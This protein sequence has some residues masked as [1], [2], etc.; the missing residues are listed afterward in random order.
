MDKMIQSLPIVISSLSLIVAAANYYRQHLRQDYKLVYNFVSLIGAAHQPHFRHHFTLANAGNKEVFVASVY[1][2]VKGPNLYEKIAADDSENFKGIFKPGEIKD[3]DVKNK[4]SI[5]SKY[6]LHPEL[7]PER[8]EVENVSFSSE[9]EER[10]T[11]KII[12]EVVVIQS[13]GVRKTITLPVYELLI[14][15][16]EAKAEGRAY[17]MTLNGKNVLSTKF[18]SA[19]RIF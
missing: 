19:N 3:F 8:G 1:F 17:D 4:V 15:F 6:Q 5:T 7:R 10:D 13:N 12:I 14:P 11:Y 2:F 9:S 18:A 16:D